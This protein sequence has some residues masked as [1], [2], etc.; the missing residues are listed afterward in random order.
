MR[1]FPVLGEIGT[2]KHLLHAHSH[3]A[4]QGWIHILMMLLLPKMFLTSEEIRRSK[5]NLQVLL[6]VPVL[7]GIFIGFL[8]Q[9]YGLVSIF[10]STLFQG[11]NYWFIYRFFKDTRSR[12]KEISLKFV[13]S[14]LLLGLLST[15]GPYIIGVI[16]AKGLQGSEAYLSA[17]FFFL[18]F[19]YNGWFFFVLV[20]L[21]FKLLETR[22]IAYEKRKGLCFYRSFLYAVFPAYALSLLGMSFREKVLFF[23][24]PA[25][26]LQIAGGV[27]FLK[28]KISLQKLFSS[29][30]VK[31]LFLIVFWAFLL[32]ILL[33]FLSVF[34]IFK[35]MAFATRPIVMAYMHLVL[36]GMISFFYLGYLRIL[37]I[38]KNNLRFYMGTGLLITGFFATEFLLVLTGLTGVEVSF[39]LFV[40][41]AMMFVG[42]VSLGFSLKR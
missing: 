1:A 41:S 34:P 26:L 25:A 20:G 4:F 38:L 6:L 39:L 33:Q 30:S 24:V 36:L 21:F 22:K 32:K 16:S 37:G 28:L 5:Y 42:T 40:F 23:A 27:C 31:L 10:F 15:L 19:Q 3:T 2:Y 13:R 18:H 9:G 14:G 17:L 29:K 8:W 12:N 11:V 7:T 35:Q